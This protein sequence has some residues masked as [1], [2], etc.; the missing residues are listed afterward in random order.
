MN[1]EKKGFAT[2]LLRKPKNTAKIEDAISSTTEP[3]VE[4]APKKQK[5]A[6]VP[7]GKLQ[8]KGGTKAFGSA[9]NLDLNEYEYSLMRRYRNI[10][11]E[12]T[13]VTPSKAAVMRAA[14]LAANEDNLMEAFGLVKS[15]DGRGKWNRPN[16]SEGN[17]QAGDQNF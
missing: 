7:A 6:S 8:R 11:E 10:I 1:T 16:G 12:A 9:I 14:L 13:G 5:S 4:D 3:P 2:G 15:T 17:G